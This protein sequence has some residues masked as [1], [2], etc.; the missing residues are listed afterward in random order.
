LLTL[1]VTFLQKK[2]QNSFTYVKVI[3]SQRWDVFETRCSS[4]LHRVGHKKQATYFVCHFVKNKLISMAFSLMIY[5]WTA[6]V[7][8]W[9]SPAS[10]NSC[11][12]TTLWKCNIT[13]GYYQRKLHQM[14]H[15]LIEMDQGRVLI[16]TYL[17][18]VSLTFIYLGCYTAMHVRNKDSWRRWPA[19][20]L[21]AKLVWKIRTYF[22][23][24]Y[25]SV[26]VF[27]NLGP[28]CILFCLVQS[29]TIFT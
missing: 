25:F 9:T 2:Y 6:H 4:K 5:K 7:M 29:S 10:P 19:K 15:S 20:I 13:A 26:R 14:Y 12:Y 28:H 27:W 18:V 8:V 1:S 16:F 11:C 23:I 17:G 21:D 24:F 3:A 22:N